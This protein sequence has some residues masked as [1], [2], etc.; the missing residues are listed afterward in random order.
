MLQQQAMCPP[1]HLKLVVTP[2]MSHRAPDMRGSPAATA[3][4]SV[5]VPPMSMTRASLSPVSAAAPLRELTGPL[6]NVRMG[7]RCA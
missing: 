6:L 7:W 4:V 1:T 2:Q 3:A 5:V